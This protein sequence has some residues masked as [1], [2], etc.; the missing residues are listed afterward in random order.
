VEL[1]MIRQDPA[2]SCMRVSIDDTRTA[3][4]IAIA[5]S[6]TSILCATLPGARCVVRPCA[7]DWQ[8]WKQPWQC[9]WSPQ[10]LSSLYV[11]Y[12]ATLRR[13]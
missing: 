8:H 10:G 11:Q 6:D 3:R 4:F 12:V 7:S 2:A 13:Q 9:L 5:I 1:L